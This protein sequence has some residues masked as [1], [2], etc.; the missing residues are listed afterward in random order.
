MT[1]LLRPIPIGGSALVR[2][3]LA[4]DPNALSFYAG[5]P[6]ELQNFQ[7]KLREVQGR[8]GAE[9]RARAASALHPTTP[10]ARLR[11]QRFV[12]EGGAVVTTGQQA[13][14]LTGPLYT[15]HKAL[16]AVALAREL[17]QR[18]GTIVLPV[19]WIASEDHDWEEANH[20][21]VL[22][23][24]GQLRRFT[25]SSAERRAL[26]MSERRLGDLEKICDEVLQALRL[27][28]DGVDWVR[29]VLDPYRRS[30]HTLAEAFRDA[31]RG[32][33]S[34]VDLFLTDAADPAVKEGSRSVLLGAAEGAG[35][36]E[37]VLLGRSEALRAAGY[38]PQ[39]SILPGG[40][41]LFL[42]TERGRERLY[43]RGSDFI[44]REGGGVF[45]R[46]ALV[47]LVRTETGRVSPNVLLRPVVESAV[48][49]TLAYVGGPG[50]V[51]YF[52]Q[53]SA[54]FAGH[55]ILPP[56]VLPRYSGA[57]VPARSRRSLA[58]LQ[59]EWSDLEAGRPS[60]IERVARG[61]LPPEVG[62]ALQE[63]RQRFTDGYAELIDAAASIDPTLSGPL[64]SARNRSMWEAH[65]AERKIVRAI[66]AREHESLARLDRVLNALRP[67]GNA[68]DRVLNVLSFLGE[69]GGLLVEEIQASIMSTWRMPE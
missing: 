18:L 60:L 44:V 36:E 48:F 59:L 25:L 69:H 16:S 67:E 46:G 29:R 10:A 5:A 27:Q 47:D 14:F 54:L 68:Q 52:A 30:D 31:L 12:E 43:R 58:S 40:T 23:R 21:V 32:L 26:P 11:L 62:A 20:A 56:L 45:S 39:V 41:N 19:F 24:V 38:H 4:G 1:E 7:H 42:R 35:E 8:F 33:F 2:D 49:P 6:F 57:I 53:A 51:A 9:E 63:L 28:G 66:K 55:G 22:D 37:E 64:G 15:V 50:E 61:H 34:E 3:Y 65:R 17:E 13:G